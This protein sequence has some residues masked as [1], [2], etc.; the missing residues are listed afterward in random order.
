MNGGKE[1]E[2]NKKWNA[3]RRGRR[4]GVRKNA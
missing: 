3:K 2:E 4:V 1:I